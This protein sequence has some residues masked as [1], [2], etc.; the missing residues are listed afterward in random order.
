MTNVT[1]NSSHSPLLVL[2]MLNYGAI[3]KCIVFT[4]VI[5][6]VKISRKKCEKISA[7]RC[8]VDN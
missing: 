8:D 5:T 3:Y 4:N 2:Q 6:S 1:F 7:N